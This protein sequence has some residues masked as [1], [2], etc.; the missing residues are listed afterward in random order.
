MKELNYDKI[1]RSNITRFLSGKGKFAQELLQIPTTEKL[2]P[3][4]VYHEEIKKALR[5]WVASDP[6]SQLFESLRD[7][8][9]RKDKCYSKPYWSAC[10]RQCEALLEEMRVAVTEDRN[11]YVRAVCALA[12]LPDRVV[13]RWL[14]HENV[15]F[16]SRETFLRRL[17]DAQYKSLMHHYHLVERGDSIESLPCFTEGVQNKIWKVL[18]PSPKVEQ[19][20]AV[21]AAIAYDFLGMGMGF[22]LYPSLDDDRKANREL[23]TQFLSKSEDRGAFEVNKEE[24]GLYWLLY[25]TLRSNALYGANK[26]VELGN[27]ICPGFWLTIALWFAF[28]VV[29]PVACVTGVLLYVLKGLVVWPLLVVGGVFPLAMTIVG[30]K[31]ACGKA[32][33]EEYWKVMFA[34]WG[35]V[36]LCGF[37]YLG[38]GILKEFVSFYVALGCVVF[39]APYA[40]L[41][42]EPFWRAPI[43]GKFLPA[44]FLAVVV[45]E[46][47]TKSLFFEFWWEQI[48][49]GV[50]Y[51]VFA[52]NWVIDFFRAQG[53]F[54][55]GTLA[56]IA[57][58]GAGMYYL[59]EFLIW[60]QDKIE[61]KINASDSRAY[62]YE[63][64]KILGVVGFLLILLVPTGGALQ[65]VGDSPL[66][67]YF[68]FLLI[69]LIPV[70]LAF[71]NMKDG[72]VGVRTR[73]KMLEQLYKKET[74]NSLQ[75][76]FE[77]AIRKNP[78]WY[79]VR[80]LGSRSAMLQTLVPVIA[81][82]NYYQCKSLVTALLSAVRSDEEVR[83]LE[84][85]VA[86]ELFSKMLD[87]DA[88]S[89]ELVRL[90]L[91]GASEEAIKEQ[92]VFER[93]MHHHKVRWVY[94]PKGFLTDDW[95]REHVFPHVKKFFMVLSWPFRMISKGLLDLYTLWK[96]F[97]EQCP[98]SPPSNRKA[99]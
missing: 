42:E 96:T 50:G 74:Y 57:V 9:V 85:F 18:G 82:R 22:Q 11:K 40:V 29:S 36:S 61:E 26:H 17:T 34:T 23:A 66:L 49:V 93:Q 60:C 64:L 94:V 54:I 47:Y 28:A 53:L 88:S 76:C 73:E 33:N 65:K 80:Y 41:K 48:L 56:V 45:W 35:V 72:G 21:K 89:R 79:D 68:G 70:L 25:R 4:P 6:S 8:L 20:S 67:V 63:R 90:I 43:L 32:Y 24:G 15:D 16:Q 69:L 3:V 77:I 78:Y 12:I 75:E 14:W 97:N 81:E 31:K 38:I 83:C 46:L 51:L 95:L 19:K 1:V 52:Y 86:S 62:F 87:H 59:S 58:Y 99:V 37:T 92:M 71:M 39:L 10:H 44:I 91:S 7:S 98:Q 2:Y 55:L 30:V 27:W 84:Q 5:L 13:R